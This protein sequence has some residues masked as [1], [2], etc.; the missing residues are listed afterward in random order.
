MTY[1]AHEKPYRYH[2]IGGV[3]NVQLGVEII[4]LMYSTLCATPDYTRCGVIL[5]C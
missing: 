1:M 2:G 4:E 5:Q 3:W